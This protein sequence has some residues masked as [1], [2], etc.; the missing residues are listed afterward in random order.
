MAEPDVEAD[1]IAHA[2][3]AIEELDSAFDGDVDAGKRS[4]LIAILI[5]TVLKRFF[6]TL[7]ERAELEQ[8]QKNAGPRKPPSGPPD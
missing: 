5:L 2:Y 1:A 3:G 6:P 7:R 8:R 4:G